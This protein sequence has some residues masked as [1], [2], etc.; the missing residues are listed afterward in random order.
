MAYQSKQ[1]IMMR[2]LKLVPVNTA[3]VS[4]SH[5]SLAQH[6]FFKSVSQTL[7]KRYLKRMVVTEHIHHTGQL[8]KF[9]L[10]VNEVEA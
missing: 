3:I 10:K 5:E 4:D 6:E 1:I 7:R 2:V 9:E 8:T